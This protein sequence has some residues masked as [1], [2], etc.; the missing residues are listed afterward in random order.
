MGASLLAQSLSA[1]YKTIPPS[2]QVHQLTTQFLAPGS[3]QAAL[4][5]DVERTGEGKNNVGR[6]VHVR[7]MGRTITTWTVS[8][9]RKPRQDGLSLSY[10]PVMPTVELPEVVGNDTEISRGILVAQS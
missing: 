8:F 6:I 3:G 4:V 10:Q 5:F 1:A 7:Q 9:M 2:F